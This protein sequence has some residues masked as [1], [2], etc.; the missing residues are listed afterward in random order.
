MRI[1]YINHYAGS[2]SYGMEFRPYYLAKR[3]VE[4]QNQVT[5]LAASHSHVRGKQ[6][7]VTDSFTT[8]NIDGIN[9]V[10]CK[11]PTYKENG[12][13]RFVNILAFVARAFQFSFKL[14]SIKKPDVVIAS[15]TYPLDIFPAWLIA[16]KAKAKLIF[17]VH[18]LWPLSPIELGGMSRMHPFILLIQMA[19]DFAYKHADQ[20]V[21]M[22]PKTLDYMTSRGMS[23]EKFNYIPNGIELQEWL[24]PKPVTSNEAK[25][26]TAKVLEYK[27]QDYF[28]VAYLGTH[29]LANCLENLVNAAEILR[30]EKVVFFFIGPGPEKE[31]LKSLCKIKELSNTVF[32][33]A[34]PKPDIPSITGLFDVNYIGLKKEPLFRFGISPNKMMDYMASRRPIINAVEAGN[35]PV[36]ESG[37]GLSVPA[38]NPLALANAIKELMNNS[39]TELSQMG[40]YGF[41]FVSKEN[42][43]KKLATKFL[44][45]MEK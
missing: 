1:L 24:N 3:W 33:D 26:I 22:L 31:S 18:D 11:T 12:I 43:Y 17:E 16:K 37:C 34:I 4:N 14:T 40:E 10:W 29:G 7:T 25:Q 44:Q 39:K 13:K 28:S 35:N 36:A 42:D 27:N 21:S 19:E 2:P 23:K 6:P 30:N 8:E 9:Y 32:F 45:V 41:Q 38:E 20:V 5:I 15:S